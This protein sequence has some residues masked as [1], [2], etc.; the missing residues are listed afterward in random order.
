MTTTMN[1]IAKQTVGASGAANITFSN[2][3]QTFTDLLIKVSA[4]STEADNASS[5]RCYFNGDTGNV[6]VT[7]LRAIGSTVASYSVSY[8]QAGYVAAGQSTVNTFGSADIYVPNYT[9]SN[10]KSSSG[11]IVQTSSTAGENYAVFSARKWNSTAA[12]TSI[13]LTTAASPWVEFSEFTLYG[14]SNSSTQNPTTPY[15]SGGDVITTDGTYWYHAFKYSGSFTPL[16]NLT[17]DYLVVAGGG[18]GSSYGGGGGGGAGG[19]R[20]TVTATGGGGSLE[21]ALSLTTNTVYTVSIGAGGAGTGTTNNGVNGSNSVFSTITSTGGGGG[22]YY[23]SPTGNAGSSGGSG[24][25]G[26]V[27]ESSGSPAGGARTT[28]QGY[29][30]GSGAARSGSYPTAGGGG[31]AGVVGANGAFNSAGGLG[32]NGVQITALATPTETGADSGY[33]AGGGAGW[34]ASYG[35]GSGGLGGGGNAGTGSTNAFA[36]DANTGGGGGGAANGV[37][38]GNGGSGIII[39]RYA[40]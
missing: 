27:S 31:G 37:G 12:I 5:L 2:I 40:V 35:G 13:T 36:G 39:V 22:G 1:L 14:I 30:G 6:T 9:T 8:A 34:L 28:N 15:A 20:S 7:E 19:L 17:C 38:S 10:T 24:G 3:P 21:S 26:G 29:A 4:R 11:D 18:G 25:G 23:N 32:G 33:Y 16:K